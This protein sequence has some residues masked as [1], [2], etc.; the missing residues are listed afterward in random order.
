MNREDQLLQ[1]YKKVKEALS[2]ACQHAGRSPE[3]VTLLAVTKYAKD[4][5]VLFLL[6]QGLI[7]HVGESRVQQAL[8]RWQSPDFVPFATV[9]HLIGHLQHNKAAKAAQFF[10]F[11]DSLDDF[12][13]AQALD[14]HVPQG[15]VLRGLVQ[16]KLTN[17]DSQSGLPLERAR[18]LVRQLRTLPHVKVCGYMAIAPQ[19][20][21]EN[22]LK[23]LFA[24]VKKAFDVDFPAGTERYLSLGM[25]EDFT[26]AVEAG[27]TL[28]RIGSKL[29]ADN[30]QEVV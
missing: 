2:T 14:R 11:I 23:R 22:E 28:P 9:K 26:I 8:L 29:F 25:S 18:E 1:N 24:E 16:I 27:S 15:K 4:S 19:G 17:R 30:L 21:A 13:T 3:E 20:G 10:D 7:K 12:S 6:R 5:D